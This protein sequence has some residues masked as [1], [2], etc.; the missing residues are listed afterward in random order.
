MSQH[1][2]QHNW[3]GYGQDQVGGG[4]GW[5]R[6]GELHLEHNAV[7]AYFLD[8]AGAKQTV[9]HADPH[10]VTD[11]AAEDLADVFGAASGQD[12]VVIAQFLRME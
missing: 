8:T 1:P 4:E 6:S 9:D 10:V 2:F 5:W 3:P 11:C 12:E 7:A